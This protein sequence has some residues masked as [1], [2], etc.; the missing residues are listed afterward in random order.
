MSFANAFTFQPPKREFETLTVVLPH[1]LE[2]EPLT[3]GEQDTTTKGLRVLPGDL[4]TQAAEVPQSDYL[5]C[6]LD[7]RKFLVLVCR[8]HLRPL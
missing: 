3:I 1:V 8:D 4:L 7:G 5:L 2:R 6:W